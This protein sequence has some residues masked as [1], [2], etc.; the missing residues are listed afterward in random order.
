MYCP[1][2]ADILLWEEWEAIHSAEGDTTILSDILEAQLNMYPDLPRDMK[3]LDA[4][5]HV[6]PLNYVDREGKLVRINGRIVCNFGDKH[7]GHDLEYIQKNDPSFLKWIMKEGFSEE[8]KSVVKPLLV[9]VNSQ[10]RMESK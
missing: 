1:T 3:S 8:V 7:K 4:V 5:C 6:L 10:L 9:K 2:L